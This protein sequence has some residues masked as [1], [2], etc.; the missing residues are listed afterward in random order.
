MTTL[1]GRMKAAVKAFREPG[2]ISDILE[3]DGT[4][5]DY[6]HRRLRYEIYWRFFENTAYRDVHTYAKRY[7]I[8]HALYKYIRPIYNPANRD[9]EFWKAH[10]WGG[11]LD[12]MAGD[13]KEIPN[14]LPIITE[15]DNPTLRGAIG[16]T[17]RWSNW[18]INKDLTTLWGSV[19]GDVGLMV[20]DDKD[21]QKV[22]LQVIHPGMIKEV[23]KDRFGNVKGYVIEE[24][25][26]APESG[27]TSRP[28][29]TPTKLKTV[30]YTE[31]AER[32]G[33]AVIYS[34]YRDSKPY[35]WT[36]NGTEWAVNYGFVPLVL[37]QHNSVGLD[38]GWS[39]IHPHRAKIHEID[40]QASMLSDYVRKELNPFNVFF[41]VD[42]PDSTPRAVKTT[43]TAGS[44]QDID[45]PYPGREEINALYGDVGGRVENTHGD[46]DI[47]AVVAYIVELLRNLEE[48][49]PELQVGKR[50][51]E[52]SGEQSGKAVREARR[53]T[54]TKAEQRRANYD[55]A[56]V[57]AQQMAVAIGGMRGYEAFAGFDLGSYE[58]GALD[59][60]IGERP[61]FA[62]DELD[63][64]EVLEKK[65]T[66]GDIPRRTRWRELGYTDEEIAE[67]E[68]DVEA[69]T[70]P[71]FRDGGAGDDESVN[72]EDQ[73][74]QGQD[75]DE[76]EPET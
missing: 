18:A 30:T 68:A 64:L 34:T 40:E 51:R 75:S 2:L 59:H 66:I 39:E 45:N 24:E 36:G 63:D 44:Q 60:S 1:W 33:D 73:D 3:I 42:A 10:L 71:A 9:G 50:S 57:R 5:A 70:P 7:K 31:V 69:A 43:N 16:Q 65:F 49:M 13:G 41:G 11:P 17:W 52:A 72:D 76:D 20:V 54:Q 27:L 61:V 37:I 62:A 46:L 25:R 23:D 19:L 58:A 8:E 53:S 15:T 4:F 28:D 67:M 12:L 55:D 21:R 48:E 38:W 22:Y 35:D 32:D 47:N 56:L 26:E 29:R 14:T 74:G 6:D